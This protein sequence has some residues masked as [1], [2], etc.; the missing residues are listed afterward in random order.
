MRFKNFIKNLSCGAVIGAAMIIPGVS[1][2]TVA[3]L[4]NIYD[5]LIN[6][7]GNMR[8]DFKVNVA[9]LLPILLGLALAFAAMYFPLAFALKRAPFPT[10]MLFVGLMVGSFPKL[11]KDSRAFG[12]KKL[13]TCSVFLP[14]AAIIAICV[15]KLFVNAGEADLSAHM[16]IWGY[17]AVM[18]VAM[19][20]SCALVI[21]GVSGSML[22]M[23]FGYY[24]PVLGLLSG[25]FA[26]FWHSTFVLAL[27]AIGLIVGFFS[28]A[29]LMKFFLKHYP[30]G[31]RWAIV[32]FV[33]GSIPA[34][35]IV[36]DYS[37]APMNGLQIAAGVI[38]CA[39]GAV[40]TYALT[41]YAEGKVRK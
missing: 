20:A 17:F 28:I 38:L 37:T 2:G 23:I 15:L 22:L 5:R 16:P 10:V 24:A 33:F 26:D 11:F 32:G 19:L 18:G 30:R 1:G 8:K 4:L 14:F 25:I 29:K 21:P 35:F 13:N 7:L 41:A 40:A 27:F 36:F 9:F 31:T 39:L 3:V 6:A 12:L 34:I